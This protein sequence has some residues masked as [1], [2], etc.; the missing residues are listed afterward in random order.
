MRSSTLADVAAGT[1][2]LTRVLVSAGVAVIAV[3]PS[4]AMRTVLRSVTS[5]PIIAAIAD[6]PARCV[7]SPA[8]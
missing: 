2:K 7:M 5:V 1:G 3:E 4:A 8:A 6:T